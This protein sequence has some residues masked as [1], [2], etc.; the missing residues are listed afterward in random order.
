M[1]VSVRQLSCKH[2]CNMHQYIKVK[3]LA[4]YSV[5]LLDLWTYSVFVTYELERLLYKGVNITLLTRQNG[6]SWSMVNILFREC[7]SLID[8]KLSIV[9]N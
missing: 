9:I 7:C 3:Q 8:A 5:K 1:T 4:K 2:R 6:A